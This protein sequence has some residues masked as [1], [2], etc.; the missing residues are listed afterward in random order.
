MIRHD[1]S[2]RMG[3]AGTQMEVCIGAVSAASSSSPKGTCET[4]LSSQQRNP[5]KSTPIQTKSGG[6]RKS[7]VAATQVRRYARTN[8]SPQGQVLVVTKAE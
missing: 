2:E 7:K 6:M 3:H 4:R 1:G 8:T 5:P